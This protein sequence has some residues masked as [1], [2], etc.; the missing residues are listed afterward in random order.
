MAE[1]LIKMKI[2]FCALSE[3]GK[4]KNNEDYYLAEKIKDYYV[5]AVAD[6]LGGHR[7]GEV[8]SRVAI[9]ELKET[10]KREEGTPKKL[11]Y[12][13]FEKANSEILHLSKYNLAL[14][15]LATTLVATIVNENKITIANL[16]DS[17][18]YFIFN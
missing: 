11:L 3:K 2:S 10:I 6:G 16:G 5:F 17:R 1:W 18:A 4:R 9:N 7:A 12:K 13:A 14:R 15:G 8:A